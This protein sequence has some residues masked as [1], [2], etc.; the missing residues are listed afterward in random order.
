MEQPIWCDLDLEAI[1]EYEAWKPESLAWALGVDWNLVN[2]AIR[3]HLAELPANLPGRWLARSAHY[4]TLRPTDREGLASL[5]DDPLFATPVQITSGGHRMSAMRDQGIR[6]ALGQ[7]LP[8][9][10][11]SS[12]PDLHAYLPE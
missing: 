12:V 5:Y 11:G 2:T 3:E 6:W 9:D 4:M 10:V 8:S 7:C 1:P